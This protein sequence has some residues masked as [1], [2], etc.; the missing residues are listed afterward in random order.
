MRVCVDPLETPGIYAIWQT[1]YG[2]D[3]WVA[4]L[5]YN[6][7][8]GVCVLACVCSEVVSLSGHMVKPSQVESKPVLVLN[9]RPCF[10]LIGCSPYTVLGIGDHMTTDHTC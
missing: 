3:W 6:V 5:N 2:R 9:I 8:A 7:C 10:L 4:L 1:A